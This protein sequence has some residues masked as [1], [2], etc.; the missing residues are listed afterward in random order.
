MS[1]GRIIIAVIALL[2]VLG[3]LNFYVGRRLFQTLT[4][5]LPNINALIYS[6]LYIVVAVSFILAR[7]PLPAFI[8]GIMGSIGSI[9][10][11]MFVYLIMFFLLT[12]IVVFIGSAVKIIPADLLLNVRF[13]AR[14]VA[15]VLSIG[16]ISYGLYNATQTKTVS[17]DVQLN[18]RLS[19]EMK[20]V[21]IADLHLGDTNGEKRL[22][23][24]VQGINSLN[25]DIVC[26]VG[27]IFNDDYY[28]IQDPERASALLKNI[29]AAH[30]VYA[31]LGNHDAG[32]TLPEMMGFLERSNIKLLNDDHVIIDDRL[33]L[34]GRLDSSPIGGFGDMER[35]E[36]SE[37]MDQ[38]DADLPIVVMDHNPA[39]IG[40]YGNEVDLILSGHSHKGQIFP[41]NLITK[42]IYTVDYGHYQKEAGS[43]HVI[44]TQGVSTWLMPMRIGTDNE[45]VS[46]GLR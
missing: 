38:I 22:E 30:G 8:R 41:G 34:I 13:C 12:D 16:V 44:V 7:L 11:G 35:I 45:I 27:D 28:M 6:G 18:G 15:I 5:L 4:F 39:N 33:V 14:I 43:P 36:L 10:M 32:R 37:V 24:I 21:M 2:G 23:D 19:E 31:V 20:I 25:P 26:I 40:E 3:G 46:I 9:W 17:Y 42:A 29:E 1:I